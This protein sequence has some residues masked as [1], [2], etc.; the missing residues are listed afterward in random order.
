MQIFSPT[1]KHILRRSCVPS[2]L[3]FMFFI[4]WEPLLL[5]DTEFM[6]IQF[7]FIALE[8]EA[9]EIR[10]VS[11]SHSELTKPGIKQVS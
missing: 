8:L 9:K 7:T 2:W 6:T 4:V 5:K 11:G 1:P 3:D 10:E